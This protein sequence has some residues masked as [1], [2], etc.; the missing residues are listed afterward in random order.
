M[1]I[2]TIKDIMKDGFGFEPS[3]RIKMFPGEH[4]VSI[5]M[6]HGKASTLYI[7][8]DANKDDLCDAL[9]S[10]YEAFREAA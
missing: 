9:E 7:S 5:A 3:C 10:S 2:K 1:T 6:H 8:M 4:L